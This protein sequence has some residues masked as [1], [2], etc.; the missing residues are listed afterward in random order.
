MMGHTTYLKSVYLD[1]AKKVAI[2]YGEEC[3]SSSQ[4]ITDVLFACELEDCRIVSYLP[5]N[6]YKSYPLIEIDILTKL[7]FG[8][9]KGYCHSVGEVSKNVHEEIKDY[10]KIM[11]EYW[12]EQL[13]TEEK[14]EPIFFAKSY[15]HDVN[16]SE[17]LRI[18]LDYDNDTSDN[19]P[20]MYFFRQ[21]KFT[22]LS[23]IPD[24]LIQEG[25]NF[26]QATQ[27]VKE[28]FA[29][30]KL[31][32]DWQHLFL[33][34]EHPFEFAGMP[35]SLKLTDDYEKIV[36][37]ANGKANEVVASLPELN[38]Y[39]NRLMENNRMVHLFN[40]PR[41]KFD[42]FVDKM[43][44]NWNKT[45]QHNL[46]EQ[47]ERL[48]EQLGSWQEVE[49][50]SSALTE[51]TLKGEVTVVYNLWDD[52]LKQG[53]SFKRISSNDVYCHIVVHESRNAE[54]TE[55]LEIFI[56]SEKTPAK[57]KEL[58]EEFFKKTVLE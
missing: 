30:N 8:I 13:L 3:T 23:S 32:Y 19:E 46:D 56:S 24:Y 42:I 39:F 44:Q 6:H 48:K 45:K 21:Q 22:L 17:L 11:R 53:I 43:V 5:V 36:V 38:D 29:A 41:L 58:A 14:P 16:K 49:L 4:C 1:K 26:Q 57:L 15:D 50:L 9:E 40:P 2:R 34:H 18:A 28:L 12:N 52:I 37:N 10:V 47:Y 54:P 7:T 33:L 31:I 27:V 51:L 20:L 25:K 55:L 35:L